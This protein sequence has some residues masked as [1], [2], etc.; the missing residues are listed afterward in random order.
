MDW[1]REVGTCVVG[2]KGRKRDGEKKKSVFTG[3]MKVVHVA[4]IATLVLLIVERTNGGVLQGLHMQ[5][6]R[7]EP[8]F[9]AKNES[10]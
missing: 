6:S 4:V 7:S 1:G 2:R 3:L 9:V 10:T 5:K 8:V